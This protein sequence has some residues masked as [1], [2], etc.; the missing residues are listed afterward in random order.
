MSAALKYVFSNYV[1]PALHKAYALVVD[2]LSESSLGSRLLSAFSGEGGYVGLVGGVDDVA[3]MADDVAGAGSVGESARM[4][5]PAEG[6]YVDTPY[7][8]VYQE[9]SEPALTARGEIMKEGTVYRAG[10]FNAG[11]HAAEGQYWGL[12]DPN[13]AP[14]Y[15]NQYGAAF[16]EVDW[17]M[18]GKLKPGEP[19]ITRT[20]PGFGPNIG[21]DIEMVTNPGSVSLDYFRTR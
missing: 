8:R 1:S 16:S 3:G 7:G 5:S 12:K 20:S 21:G 15:A 14:G 17:T 13:I 6:Y 10:S 2:K 19:F 4:L 18:A 11:T 9:F